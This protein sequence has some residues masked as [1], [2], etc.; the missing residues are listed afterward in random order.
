[1][2][3]ILESLPLQVV[4]ASRASAMGTLRCVI[5]RRGDVYLARTSPLGN[6]LKDVS[7]VS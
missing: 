5:E 1:M 2:L 7:Q 6:N 4:D 3:D